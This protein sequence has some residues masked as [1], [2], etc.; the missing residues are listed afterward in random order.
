MPAEQSGSSS[1]SVRDEAR[2]LPDDQRAAL[3]EALR[4]FRKSTGCS[5]FVV[6][7]TYVSG[8]SIRD[9]A[10]ELSNTWMPD[11]LGMVLA[12]DRSSSS[13]A[14]VP[15]KAMWRTYPTPGLVEAF[16][17]AAAILQ[18]DQQP[19]A[20]RLTRSSKTL[21]KRISALDRQ[22]RR[23]SQM[24][25][26]GRER[27][28]GLAFL[29][30]LITGAMVAAVLIAIIR[31]RDAAKSVQHLFPVVEIAPRF[32]APHGGGVIAEIQFT[33]QQQTE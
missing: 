3:D 28:L 15:T 29:G 23:Q 13:H 14:I 33:R 6:T 24:L 31:R 27:W 9:H 19:L 32:G 17:E 2:I 16:R 10:E 8:K 21:M 7:A 26:P 11:G 25:V 20:E 12:C 30:F 1:E 5:L 18:D 4:T 22:L